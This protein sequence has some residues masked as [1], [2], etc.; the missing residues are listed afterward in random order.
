MEMHLAAGHHGSISCTICEYEPNN[1]FHATSTYLLE[2]HMQEQH[3]IDF[4]YPCAQCDFKATNANALKHHFEKMHKV[5]KCE[6]CDV[7][8]KSAYRLKQHIA[9]FHDIGKVQCA[10]CDFNAAS[11]YL[12]E[13]HQKKD[14]LEDCFY[15]CDKC[16]YKGNSAYMLNKHLKAKH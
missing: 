2:K 10:L 12:V 8:E 16:G 11:K 15:S 13:K 3:S 9:K 7:Q 5:H 6:E 4:D 14:H 1:V